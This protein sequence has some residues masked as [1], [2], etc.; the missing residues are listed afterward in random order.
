M[1]GTLKTDASGLLDLFDDLLIRQDEAGGLTYVNQAFCDI[2]GGTPEDWIGRSFEL[3]GDLIAADGGDLPEMDMVH[4][5]PTGRR[6]IAWRSR[7]LVDANGFAQGLQSVGR[8]ISHRKRQEETLEELR[9]RAEDANEAK[10]LFLATMSHE[11]R[12]PMNCVIGMASLLKDSGL[13]AAQDTYVNAIKESGESLL[14]LINDILDYSKI[15]AGRLEFEAAPFDLMSTIHSVTE[16]LASRCHDKGIEIGAIIDPNCPTSVIGDEGRLRQVLINLLGNGVKFTDQGG[17]ILK[18]TCVKESEDEAQIRFDVCDTGIGIAPSALE[19]IFEE[20][21]QA[22]ASHSREYE[23]TGLGL[24]ICAKLVTAMQGQIGVES[25]E[26]EGSTFYATLPFEIAEAPPSETVTDSLVGLKVMIASPSP[27][28]REVIGHALGVPGI[29]IEQVGSVADA[30]QQFKAAQDMPFTTL[31]CDYALP[32]EGA[33]ELSKVFAVQT[34]GSAARSLLLLA[35]E[36]RAILDTLKDKNFDGYLIKPVRQNSLV[37]R[38]AC[39]HGVAS[40]DADFEAD[41]QALLNEKT[42]LGALASTRPLKILMAEDND[43]NALLTQTQI[44][45]MGH[46]VDRVTNGEDAI[47]ALI[48]SNFDIVLMDVRMPR[49][50]GL[51]ATQRIRERED[52]ISDV[53]IIALTAN[54]SEDDRKICLAAGMNDFLAKPVE[55]AALSRVLNRWT[56]QPGMAKVS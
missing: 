21:A 17:V 48:N 22:D 36:D 26:G 2:F 54:A 50:D 18:V 47:R 43:I 5:T 37:Q 31:I 16:L 34:A 46:I 51:E 35:P 10:S 25:T 45:K 1:A 23:G 14:S 7:S 12:T 4:E 9:V 55:A 13:T 42:E 3:D 19:S 56:N 8:D 15:E 39:V 53:P 52:R 27:I 30:M 6:W 44:T 38:V 33:F 49:L 28:L 29:V 24:A 20:F 41:R 40:T 11:I 32:R